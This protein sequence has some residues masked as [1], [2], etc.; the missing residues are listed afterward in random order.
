MAAIKYELLVEYE[1]GD[2]DEVV[3][4]QREVAEWERQPFGCCFVDVFDKSA[5]NFF[6]F[7]AWAALRRQGRLPINPQTK[8]A[9]T[10]E[11]WSEMAVDVGD[12]KSDADADEGDEESDP[13]R[14]APSTES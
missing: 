7:I 6:R 8:K 3:A 14:K 10:Y 12:T 9:A 1:N 13:T 2:T 4:G 5:I 11:A